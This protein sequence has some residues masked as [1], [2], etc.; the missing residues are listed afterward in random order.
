MVNNC[1]NFESPA[2][3][4]IIELPWLE[5]LAVRWDAFGRILPPDAT[6]RSLEELYVP[7]FDHLREAAIEVG[8]ILLKERY[9]TKEAITDIR[10]GMYDPRMSNGY[11][12]GYH[13]D[14]SPN[15]EGPASTCLVSTGRAGNA[16]VGN[17]R[18]PRKYLEKF[19]SKQ[20]FHNNMGKDS[21]DLRTIFDISEADIVPL[22][23][24]VVYYFPVYSVHSAPTEF[25]PVGRNMF[26]FKNLQRD[27]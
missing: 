10:S 14:T 27:K 20:E 26:R 21:S 19:R 25:V 12:L 7:H 5:E 6:M 4:E 8:Q 23:H 2:P 13:Y 11:N 22:K 16:A 1:V 9:T 24:N 18:I 15:Y 3:V 17:I